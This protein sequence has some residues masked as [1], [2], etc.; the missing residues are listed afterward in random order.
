MDFTYEEE[1]CEKELDKEKQLVEIMNQYGDDVLKLVYSYVRRQD[2]A[3]DIT[4]DVFLKVYQKIH[5]FQY[6]SSIKTWVYRIA[7]NSSKDYLK[8]WHVRNVEVNESQY[9]Y[10]QHS[11]SDTPEN[12]LIAKTEEIELVNTVLS[13]PLKYREIIYLY[14]YEECSITV[15]SEY[16]G[17][18]ENTVK[19]RL[20]LARKKLKKKMEGLA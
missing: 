16:L 6:R 1:G 19:T 17:I 20:Y 13:L 15:I 2:I 4:Q 8:S 3:E 9:D 5:S 14:Y 18:K 10:L 7:I 12:K 11:E